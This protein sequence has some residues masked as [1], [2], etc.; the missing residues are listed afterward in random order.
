MEKKSFLFFYYLF[1]SGGVLALHHSKKVNV[2]CVFLGRPELTQLPTL[3]LGIYKYD[4][5]N[6]I[7]FYVHTTQRLQFLIESHHLKYH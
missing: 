7:Q 6:N 2:C 1:S 4:V 5:K 3:N